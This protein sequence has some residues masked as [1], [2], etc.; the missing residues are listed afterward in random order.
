MI[1]NCHICERK[2]RNVCM[3]L[4]R[5]RQAR[6]HHCRRCGVAVCSE[7]SNYFQTLPELAYYQPTRICRNC[8]EIKLIANDGDFNLRP[9]DTDILK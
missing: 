1:E 3:T 5:H 9:Y 8:F 4:V 6:Q 7:C 2:F